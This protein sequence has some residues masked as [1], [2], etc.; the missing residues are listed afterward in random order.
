MQESNHASCLKQN[1][2]LMARNTTV[3]ELAADKKDL[4][5]NKL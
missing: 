5:V 2:R 1:A 3:D 4:K